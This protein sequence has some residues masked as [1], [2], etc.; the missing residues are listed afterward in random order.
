M[1]DPESRYAALPILREIG[2]D[3]RERV[4]IGRRFLPRA[5]TM[6]TLVELPMSA[7]DRLDL[8]AARVL[9]DP[10]QYWRICDAN[11]AMDPHDLGAEPNARIRIA[12]PKP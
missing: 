1:F 11:E 10:L 12:V 7:D 3:G 4:Y 9:G 6:T 2:V 8:V 5:G